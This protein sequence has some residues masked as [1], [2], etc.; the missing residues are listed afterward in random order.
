MKLSMVMSCIKFL[1]SLLV[2]I[3]IKG[4][5]IKGHLIKGHAQDSRGFKKSVRVTHHLTPSFWPRQ[6]GCIILAF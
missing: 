4:H 3:L 2:N 6:F 1:F 5:L